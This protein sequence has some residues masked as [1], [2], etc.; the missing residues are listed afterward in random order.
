MKKT[1]N[2]LNKLIINKNKRKSCFDSKFDDNIDDI[3][4]EEEEDYRQPSVKSAKLN[5]NNNI[6][7]TSSTS[8]SDELICGNNSVQHLNSSDS[9]T[10][11]T[12]KTNCF[13]FNGRSVQNN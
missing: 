1:N 11:N 12:F 10:T 9:L 3:D 8:S 13:E 2:N 4:D 5:D 7:I 6:V